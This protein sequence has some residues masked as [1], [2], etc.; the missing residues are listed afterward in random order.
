MILKG[1]GDLVDF[2]HTKG[3]VNIFG[4]EFHEHYE[5]YLLI[6]GSVEFISTKT[7]QTIKPFRLVV[8][9]PGEYHN[10]I[11]GADI[12][13][14]ERCIINIH[15]GFLSDEIMKSA[16]QNKE[17]IELSESS[18]L[19]Q[20]YLYLAN[21]LTSVDPNDFSIILT[22]IATDIVM[23]IKNSVESSLVSTDSIGTYSDIIKYIDAHYTKHLNLEDLSKQLNYSVSSLCSGFKKHFGTTIKKYVTQKRMIAAK[24]DLQK[25]E[26]AEKTCQKYGFSNY[27]TFFRSY[28]KHFGVAPSEHK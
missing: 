10:F 21:A 2:L 11:P 13:N 18:R 6:G 28:K 27:S 17:I 26:P 9:P 12:E 25:G 20:N 7:K 22:A 14:Y 15:S 1:Y 3:N 24:I 8:I 19:V 23:L 5:F 4:R 16:V